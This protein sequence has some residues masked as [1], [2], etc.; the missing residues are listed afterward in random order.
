ML[1]AP[2]L[3]D[4]LWK[5]VSPF[6]DPV[7][8]S[9]IKF[10]AGVD[11]LKRALDCSCLPV[12]YGGTAREMPISELACILGVT[13]SQ[14]GNCTIADYNEYLETTCEVFYDAVEDDGSYW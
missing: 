9:K 2:L 3:F 4:A 8:K 10:V 6:V 13:S 5:I 14:K 11:D 1:D 7:S 12:A